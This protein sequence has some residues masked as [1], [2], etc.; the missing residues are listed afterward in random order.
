M[1]NNQDLDFAVFQA[2]VFR[3]E[4][5]DLR[6][7]YHSQTPG[8]DLLRFLS[9]ECV[10][11]TTGPI[12]RRSFLEKIGSF[13]ENLLSMQ[14]LEMHVRA[15]AARGS[16][17][18]FRGADHDIRGH[19]DT[20]RTSSRHFAD[21]DFIEASEHTLGLLLASVQRAGL[22][23]WSRR[24]ALIGLYFSL[25]ET[26]TRLGRPAKGRRV[27]SEGGRKCE[28][29]QWLSFCG[30]VLLFLLRMNPS[31]RGLAA[32]L[33]SKW[34]DWTRLRPEPVFINAAQRTRSGPSTS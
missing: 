6:E 10:W 29:P 34:K 26:W 8:D 14:D 18:F 20:S 25:G 30:S 2:T 22:V 5:D 28:A 1:R 12:W 32:R 31:P 16:Y 13:D 3:E 23:T 9:L 11:Q 19:V 33:I 4:R 17:L 27:W 7:V 24:R 15:L 21:P